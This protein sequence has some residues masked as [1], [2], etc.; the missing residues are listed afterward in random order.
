MTVGA[1]QGGFWRM[2]SDVPH[3]SRQAAGEKLREFPMGA[4]A[5]FAPLGIGV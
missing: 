1:G 3:R 2:T 5:L 4:L